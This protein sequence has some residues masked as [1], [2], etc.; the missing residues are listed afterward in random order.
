MLELVQKLKN[1]Y[2]AEGTWITDL[3]ANLIATINLGIRQRAD[4]EVD[5]NRIKSEVARLAC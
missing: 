3:E 4:L 2:H 5:F 1:R